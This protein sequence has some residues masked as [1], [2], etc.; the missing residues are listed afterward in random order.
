MFKRARRWL[1]LIGLALAAGA[2]A[3]DA[4]VVHT[5]P[6]GFELKQL[7]HISAPPDKVYAA[8]IKPA[9]WWS[10]AHTFSGD[11]THLTLDARAGGCFCEALPDGGSVAHLTVAMAAPSERLLMRGAMGPFMGR[12]VDG[13]LQIA[14]TPA[15]GGTDLTLTNNLG[16]YLPEGFEA[17][18]G[19]ADAMLAEQMSRLK[20]YVE[21]GAATLNQP[22]HD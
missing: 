4:A 15:G 18:A 12:G 1:S 16:G 14:L 9:L 22:P 6:F 3:A 8:L 11:P 20:R 10:P 7:I 17:W 5:S 2:S 19:K 13:A 21:T